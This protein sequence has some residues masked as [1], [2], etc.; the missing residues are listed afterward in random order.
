MIRLPEIHKI[1][2]E[3]KK[4]G[5]TLL[6]NELINCHQILQY[7]CNNHPEEIQEMRYTSFRLKKNKGCKKCYIQHSKDKAYNLAVKLFKKMDLTIAF[8]RGDFK[9]SN[10]KLKYYCNKHPD[11]I[12]EIS[13]NN[14]KSR[15]T[16][17]GCIYCYHDSLRNSIEKIYG[18]FIDKKYIPIFKPS[19]YTESHEKLPYICSKHPELKTQYVSAT[20]LM[21]KGGSIIHC[22]KCKSEFFSKIQTP[23]NRSP[24]SIR[25]RDYAAYYEWQKIVYEKHNYTC[26]KCGKTHS[27]DNRINAHHIFGYSE[28]PE[29]RTNI[30][31]GIA[32]C[33]ICHLDFHKK[34]G[35]KNNN[36]EQLEEFLGDKIEDSK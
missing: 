25:H 28:Y 5:L 30:D 12:Q 33:A 24:R 23:K 27:E 15:K 11:I 1:K 36:K 13:Y 17:N 16:K 29:L 32:L 3:F 7:I 9:D 34:Y 22:K 18:Y 20:L 14:L 31:N 10:S 35:F 8:S 19:E 26:S 4:L 2:A 21:L 6:S